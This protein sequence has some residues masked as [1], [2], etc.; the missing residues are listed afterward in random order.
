MSISV[1]VLDSANGRP[2]VDLLV[3][4]SRVRDGR[5]QEDASGRTDADGCL[6]GY[7]P[8][9]MARGMHRIDVDIDEYFAG[10]GVTPFFPRIVIIFRVTDV[11]VSYHIRL[12]ITPHAYATYHEMSLS[13]DERHQHLRPL[14][15]V[16]AAEVRE[17]TPDE[18]PPTWPDGDLLP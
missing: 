2:A 13:N 12:L 11:T 5:W 6:T 15:H 17:G 10:I 18:V 4:L 14:T 3:R 8:G 9:R 16:L 1:R 7:P